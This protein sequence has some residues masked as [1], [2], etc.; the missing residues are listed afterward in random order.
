MDHSMRS[1]RVLLVAVAGL[2]VAKL[3]TAATYL[4][5]SDADLAGRA[6]V[7]ARATVVSIAAELEPVGETDRPMT[8]VNLQLLEAIKGSP[9]QTFVV[10]LPGGRAG[11][12]VWWVPGTPR[13][14]PGEEVLLMLGPLPG[15]PGRFRLTEF[16]LS[17]FDLVSD[18][19]GHRYAVRPVFRGDED[20]LVS[21]R[22]A[23]VSGPAGARD[24]D[25]FLDFLRAIARREPA[26]DVAY[27]TPVLQREKWVNIGGREPGGGCTDAGADIPCLWRW[28][29]DA[30]QQPSP[31]AVLSVSGT[32]TNLLDDEPECGTDSVCDVQNAATAWHGVAGADVRISGPA[33]S[34][35]INVVLDAAQSQDDGKTWSTPID[36]SG[37]VIGLGGPNSG[38]GPRTYRGDTEYYGSIDGTVSM[39]KSTCNLHYSAA[40]FRSAVLHEVGHVLGLGHPD[41]N[42]APQHVAEESIHSTT[43]STDWN[44]AVMH[45]VI[46]SS[47][48][49]TP[50]TDDIQ[51]IQYYYGTAAVG[52]PPVANFTYSS[53]PTAGQP[54]TFTDASTGGA[55]GWTW[56]FGDSSAPVTTRNATHA[57]S[58]AQ[59]FNV[60]LT[61]GSLSGSSSITRAVTI[62][63]GASSCTQGGGTLCLNN[64]RFKTTITWQK[65]DGTS[66]SGTGVPLTSDSGYFWF[67]NDT[68]IETVVKVLNACGL[69]GHYWVFAAGLTNVQA[70]LTV[71]DTA[72]GTPKQYQN[73]QGTPFAPIQ[74]TTAFGT[75]P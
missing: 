62:G 73:P 54:V 28:F 10:S 9:G 31:N 50:Q 75:C 44:N 56:D 29:W 63:Q 57:F 32:Q 74:D 64:N 59:T 68:N 7:I 36:C 52:A 24:A 19:A 35:N 17:K 2:A 18:A 66:G 26:P 41:D 5:M 71:V 8:L 15:H 58:S 33:A 30:T 12:K 55:T 45:S 48:P 13:F 21:K 3:L 47:K 14:S 1:S 34:G 11:D 51:G 23:A 27:G 70:T 49:D 67:F 38:Y 20:L 40:T 22:A 46:V 16:G 25:S 65:T 37:G 39:R 53:N 72:N 4:P 42:G 43:S 69:N 6:P 60:T 61:A